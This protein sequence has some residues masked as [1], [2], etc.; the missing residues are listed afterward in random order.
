MHSALPLI[1]VPIPSISG[2]LLVSVSDS[3]TD[4]KARFYSSFFDCAAGVFG[5]A[6]SS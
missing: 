5:V 3:G 6:Y 2:G 4:M 1:A